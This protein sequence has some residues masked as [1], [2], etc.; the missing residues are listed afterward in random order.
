MCMII[1]STYF[2]CI[3]PANGVKTLRQLCGIVIVCHYL[4]G[5]C[6][7]QSTYNLTSIYQKIDEVAAT[8]ID[9]NS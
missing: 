6:L 9:N 3:S 5:L 1:I 8:K 4:R 2:A 7:K